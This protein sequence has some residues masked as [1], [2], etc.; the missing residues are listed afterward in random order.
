VIS[1]R[2]SHLDGPGFNLNRFTDSPNGAVVAF[3]NSSVNILEFGLK[4]RH[5]HFVRRPSTSTNENTGQQ[6][7]QHKR[8]VTLKIMLITDLNKEIFQH[9]TP[10]C[11]SVLEKALQVFNL[12]YLSSR[13]D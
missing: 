13:Q 7:Q 5:D 6:Q 3:H 12:A 4:A 9:V 10:F 2:D 11:T 8:N 1:T